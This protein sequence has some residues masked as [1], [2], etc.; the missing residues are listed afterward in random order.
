[1][2]K[3]LLIVDVQNEYLCKKRNVKRFKFK[4]P[5]KLARN[6]NS[7]IEE[8]VKEG[9]IIIYI[10]EVVPNNLISKIIVGHSLRGTEGAKLYHKLNVVSDNYFEKQ[11]SDAFSNKKLKTFIKEN[12]ITEVKICGIDAGACVAATANG[13]LKMGLKVSVIIKSID[14]MFIQRAKLYR[15]KLE[16]KGVKYI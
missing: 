15:E 4:H 8:A 10:A 7:S 1:M 6:I 2:A 12:D 3:A 13:A 16:K 11:L 14:T 5:E 9:Y